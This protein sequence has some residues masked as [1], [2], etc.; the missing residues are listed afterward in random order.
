MNCNHCGQTL[1]GEETKFC[2]SCGK[3]VTAQAEK[4]ALERELADVKDPKKRYKLIRAA[5]ERSPDD[6]AANEALLFHGRLHEPMRGGRRLDFSIIKSNLLCIFDEPEKLRPDEIREKLQELLHDAQLERTMAL[7]PDAQ[8]YF[9]AYL[10]RMAREYIDLFIRGDS[11][12]TSLAFGIPR[13]GE[14]LARR[15][16][17]P[18]RRMLQNIDN[19][20]ELDDAQRTL[21]REAL[22]AGYAHAFPGYT[23]D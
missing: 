7:A 23:L 16:G 1:P 22:Y 8:A 13:M 5:L 4:S 11:R 9:A 15:C 10:Y 2:P 20:D 6:F 19:S 12:Y 17:E 3:P 18:V 21:L 14:S